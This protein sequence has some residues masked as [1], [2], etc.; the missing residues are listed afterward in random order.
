MID[1]Q[2]GSQSLHL[3][4]KERGQARALAKAKELMIAGASRDR[5]RDHKAKL[6]QQVKDEMSIWHETRM[7]ICARHIRRASAPGETAA[8][9]HMRQQPQAGKPRRA[10]ATR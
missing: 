9:G 8:G 10:K 7:T 1:S 6:H 5:T 2:P 3:H 4:R